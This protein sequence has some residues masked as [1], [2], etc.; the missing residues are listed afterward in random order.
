ME[1][2]GINPDAKWRQSADARARPFRTWYTGNTIN[3]S[4]GQGPLEV[5]PLQAACLYA[6]IANG[7]TYFYPKLLAK[8]E[9][10]PRDVVFPVRSESLGIKR[11]AL[12]AVREGL[13]QVAQEPGGTAYRVFS[14]VSYLKVAGKT[15][16][17]QYGPN[18]EKAYAWFACYAP[19]DNPE[20]VVV[21]LVEEGEAGGKTAAPLAKQV[22]V[23]FFTTRG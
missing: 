1:A 16:T 23:H 19:C 3:L 4:I 17:A 22:L 13:R 14:D 21:V 7:G 6:G 2:S 5:T 12:L 8:I 20:I 9:G 18:N 15:G 10:G 11:S